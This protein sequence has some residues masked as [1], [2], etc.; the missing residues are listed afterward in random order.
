MLSGA[1][2]F[3]IATFKKM[4]LRPRQ[5]GD[6]DV[7]M[8][9]WAENGWMEFSGSTVNATGGRIQNTRIN[10]GDFWW[11]WVDLNHQPCP[12]QYEGR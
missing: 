5:P 7:T 1:N 6:Q 8:L 12:Y 2:A 10:T 9:H 4:K 11:A 3:E